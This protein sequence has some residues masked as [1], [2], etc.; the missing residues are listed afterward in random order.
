VRRPPI[1]IPGTRRASSALQ[2]VGLLT[3]VLETHSALDRMRAQRNYA[4][5]GTR[6]ILA[7]SPFN[8]SSIRS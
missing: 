5:S 4:R 6:V 8:R 3:E 2:R 1:P 7:P